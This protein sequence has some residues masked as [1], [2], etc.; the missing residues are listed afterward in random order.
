[1]QRRKDLTSIAA[2]HHIPFAAQASIG[3][4]KDLVAKAEKAFNTPGPAFINV[5]APCPRGW[6]YDGSLTIEVSKLAFKTKFWPQFEVE[7]GVWKLKEVREKDILPIEEFLKT[8]GRFK[9]LFKAGNE[10]LIEQMQKEV[11]EYYT[12]L[13]KMV[14][15]TN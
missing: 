11:D 1:V 5:F 9:H 15:A 8:Q 10:P 4:W 14:A 13:Q 2:A 7:N 12:Y 6:R 3:D